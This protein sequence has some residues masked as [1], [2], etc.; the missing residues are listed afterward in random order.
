LV[1]LRVRSAE[2]IAQGAAGEYGSGVAPGQLGGINPTGCT[3]NCVNTSIATAKTLA[4]IPTI[5]EASGTGSLA[6]IEEA[7][8]GGEYFQRVS[9]QAEIEAMLQK[10]G[11]GAQGIVS[12]I[13]PGGGGHIWNVG[14]FG[15]NVEFIDGQSIGNG[16]SNFDVYFYDMNFLPISLPIK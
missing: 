6:T 12:G 11:D 8:G 10:A 14:N 2:S 4:G 1:Q 16:L 13:A 9:G 7:L 15:G 3:T 5:A